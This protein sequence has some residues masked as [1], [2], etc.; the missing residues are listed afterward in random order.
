MWVSTWGQIYL[1]CLDDISG[2]REKALAEYRAASLTAGSYPEALRAV[3][4]GLSK[5]FGSKN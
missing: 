4:S 5:P 1:G 2:E 3:Q